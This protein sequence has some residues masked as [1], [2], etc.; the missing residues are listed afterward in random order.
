[1]NSDPSSHDESTTSLPPEELERERLLAGAL[2]AHREGPA[3]LDAFCVANQEHAD[4][5]RRQ[6]EFL[7]E[8]GLLGPATVDGL[9][10]F[11]G[12]FELLHRIGGGGM[13]VV[14][15]ARQQSIA[16]DVAVKVVRPE[17]LPFAQAQSR[18]QREIAAVARLQHPAIVRI[19]DAGEAAGVP[20]LA[21]ERLHGATLAELLDQLRERPVR[22]RRGGDLHARFSGSWPEAS[23]ALVLEIAAG[24][25]HAHVRGVLHRD[26]KPSNVLLTREGQPVVIDFGLAIGDGDPQ[27]TRTQA[28]IGSL[29]YCAPERLAGHGD[30]DDPRVDVYG[31]GALLYELLAGAPAFA[32]SDLE[33]VRRQVLRGEFQSVRERNPDVARDLAVVVATAM[34]PR[35][36]RYATMTAFAADLRAV[37]EHRPIAARP[38]GPVL[39]LVRWVQRNATLSA[40]LLLGLV[41]AVGVPFALLAQEW[42]RAAERAPLLATASADRLLAM[43]RDL[44]PTSSALLTGVAGYPSWLQ[45]AEALLA[46]RPAF[47]TAIATLRARGRRAAIGEEPEPLR[48]ARLRSELEDATT[49]D[50]WM[51]GAMVWGKEARQIPLRAR[52]DEIRWQ[53]DEEL[54]WTFADREDEQRQGVL[55]R[56]LW[57]LQQIERLVGDVQ[58][59]RGEAEQIA[60]AERAAAADYACLAAAPRWHGRHPGYRDLV[61]SPQAGLLPL[62]EDPDSGLL[63]FAHLPSGPA[64]RRDPVTGR[65]QIE[66]DTGIVLVLLP[67]GVFRMGATPD[68]PVN[69]DALAVEIEGPCRE[70]ELA[71][72]F[73]AK[74]E[75]T[76]A[77]WVRL[78]GLN[79]SISPPGSAGDENPAATT[80]RHPIED[81]TWWEARAALQ[82]LGLELPTE[83][84]WE[85][86]ARAGGSD[87]FGG[88]RRVGVAWVNVLEPSDPWRYHAPVGTFFANAFGLYDM[89]GNVA[90]WC[91]DGGER[92]TVVPLPGNGQRPCRPDCPR[93]AR[94]GH[95]DGGMSQARVSARL[96]W[97][98][99]SALMQV[100]VRAARRVE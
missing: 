46:E 83:A 86:A 92:Y 11:L 60:A 16:R 25:E 70:V 23:V 14:F 54:G 7:G 69:R 2:A 67:G 81:V 28:Q 35:S 6:V 100:G 15:A 84:Q 78:T 24:L 72:F 57:R 74:Y 39:R 45:R 80:W 22:Q 99:G 38:P 8:V 43:E 52:I 62:G 31:L 30:G 13:G 42:A 75:L 21:M 5:L 33:R 55:A 26:L 93:A 76:Q 89:L 17:L 44:W 65:L 68:D 61:L 41:L 88:V 64:A 40:L 63:E 3:A 51:E 4:W 37:L 90:E 91:V 18:F 48:A 34:A 49:S 53:L 27:I 77:Q 97:P 20:F 85:Y 71:P 47:V 66:D 98:P 79:P 82:Q 94:G 1:M 58:R 87:P 96:A 36:R 73:L 19:V 95:Y 10:R 32:G 29:P 9:P 56:L 12:D 59:R 50:V